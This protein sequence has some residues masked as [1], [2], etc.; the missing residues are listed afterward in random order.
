[1]NKYKILLFAV[2]L[3]FSADINA[4]NSQETDKV[5][6]LKEIINIA[7]NQSIASKYAETNR[8]NRFWQF[9]TYRSNYRP[10]LRLDG[11]IPAYTR[12]FSPITQ[13]DGTIAFRPVMNNNSELNLS[14]RQP[15]GL[16]GATI[17]LNSGVNRF[18]NFLEENDLKRYHQYSGT[19]LEIGLIQPLFQFNELRWNRKI[20]P[21]R[22][23]ESQKEYFEN[24][25]LPFPDNS[26]TNQM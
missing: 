11:T 1:M 10:Q 9:Q 22:Y 4:Q 24:L 16:T 8:E 26:N 6:S 17:F 15:I 5:Y 20:E 13:Q 3:F 2:I 7:R 23:E 12:A 19:P 25:E 14:I 18:D 21:L